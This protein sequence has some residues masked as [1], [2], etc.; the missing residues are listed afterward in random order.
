MKLKEKNRKKIKS[1]L[2]DSHY[3]LT[4]SSPHYHIDKEIPSSFFKTYTTY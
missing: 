4:P 3:F 1:N 2:V